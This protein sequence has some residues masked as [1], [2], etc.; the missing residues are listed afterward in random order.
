MLKHFGKELDRASSGRSLSAARLKSWLIDVDYHEMLQMSIDEDKAKLGRK[1]RR[2]KRQQD[3]H[4][5]DHG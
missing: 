5:D 3:S 4:Q 1:Q 2:K